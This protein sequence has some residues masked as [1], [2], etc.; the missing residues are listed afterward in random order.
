[1]TPFYRAAAADALGR[2]NNPRATS[3]LIETLTDFDNSVSVRNAAANAL[4][5]L[6]KYAPTEQLRAIAETYPEV[7]TRRL[8]M[9]VCQQ[10]RL[11]TPAPSQ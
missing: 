3:V 7:T 1:M 10:A 8:L 2:I 6:S 11:S 5:R 9:Q 4:L